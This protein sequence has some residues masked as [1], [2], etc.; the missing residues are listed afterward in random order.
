MP[1]EDDLTVG[2]ER[3]ARRDRRARRPWSPSRTCCSAPRTSWTRRRSSARAREVGA[4]VILDTYQS[5]G[6]VPVDVDGARRR[7]RGRRLPEVAVRRAR[8]TR[9]STRGPIVLKTAQ[10]SFTGWLS[11][12]ASVRRSTSTM[13]TPIAGRR[14]AHDERDAVDPGVL[15]GAGRARHHQR[16]R[17]RSDPRAVEA[18]DGA[19][20]RA[21]RRVRLHVRGVARS[22]SGWPAPSR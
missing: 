20:A 11:R 5:A 3:H 22:R 14:D 19:A 10:P 6:I 21:G 15:R 1:A 2:T 16:G 18:D 7:L 12:A 4:T 8:A 9:F 13:P 17:R